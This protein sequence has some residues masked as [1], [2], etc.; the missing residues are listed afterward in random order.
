M[1]QKTYNTSQEAWA[2]INEYL[3]HNEPEEKKKGGG[4]DGGICI[5]YDAMLTIRKAYV[6]PDFDFGKVLGYSN[7]KW[8][9]LVNNYVNINYLDIIKSEILRV[10]AQK[11]RVYQI[12]KH[13]NNN[14]ANGKDCLISITFSRRL[15][16]DVPI[17]VFHTRATEVTKRLLFDFLLVQ[18]IGEYIYGQKQ[19]FS[20]IFYT[21]MAFLN[22][23]SFCMY[24]LYRKI[25]FP[26]AGIYGWQKSIFSALNRFLT[27]DPKTITYLSHRRMALHIRD[28]S[29]AKSMKAS[30]LLL[31]ANKSI[32]YPDDCLTDSARTAY[33]RK[34][35]LNK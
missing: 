8:S 10:E 16:S 27:A 22:Q 13:F 3:F 24:N 5:A 31:I 34:L 7:H 17:L 33:K 26:K 11:K 35:K 1:L 4:R 15:N 18:R 30:Q 28:N 12:T 32:I 6:D 2:G 23:E 29:K 25:K 20:M 21:P 9:H 14:H 19:S